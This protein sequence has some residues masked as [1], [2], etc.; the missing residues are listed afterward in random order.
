MDCPAQGWS[1]VVGC[2]PACVRPWFQATAPL[3]GNSNHNSGLGRWLSVITRCVTL[4]TRVRIHSTAVKASNP[5][6]WEL[7]PGSLLGQ[8]GQNRER[9]R[10]TPNFR[11]SHACIKNTCPHTCEHTHTHHTCQNKKQKTQTHLRLVKMQD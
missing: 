4:R 8:T 11:S 10:K 3:N 7:A 6:P 1:S 9:C 5:S 2:S